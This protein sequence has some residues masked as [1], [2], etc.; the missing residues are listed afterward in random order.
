MVSRIRQSLHYDAH[1]V[2]GDATMG[3]FCHQLGPRSAPSRKTPTENMLHTHSHATTATAAL[4]EYHLILRILAR[5]HPH[6]LSRS[7]YS[8]PALCNARWDA[9]SLTK[10]CL[11]ESVVQFK[12][13]GVAIFYYNRPGSSIRSFHSAR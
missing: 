7:S 11:F 2:A 9:R 12:L 6:L 10:N 1:L 13:S 4:R 3:A 5:S 8:Y